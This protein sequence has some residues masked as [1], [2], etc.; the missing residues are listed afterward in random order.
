LATLE[1][2]V[3]GLVD[4]GSGDPALTTGATANRD[5]EGKSQIV[6]NRLDFA[7]AYSPHRL[8]WTALDSLSMSTLQRQI[9]EKFLGKLA[10]SKDADA[11]QIG[12]LRKL[13]A[14]GTKPRADDLVKIFS[15]PAG[16]GDLKC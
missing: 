9:I 6:A 13:F 2:P 7:L 10:Q 3:S 16:G 11:D 12:Q 14:S 5:P 1:C 8:C 4:E 15:R